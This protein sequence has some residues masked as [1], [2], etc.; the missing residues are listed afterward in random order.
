V[1][2]HVGCATESVGL[3]SY[4]GRCV[5]VCNIWSCRLWEMKNCIRTEIQNY[6]W[7]PQIQSIIASCV[8]PVIW[9][10]LES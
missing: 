2:A 3:M 4:D 10:H 6:M 1:D 7:Q 5:A 9:L 8:M